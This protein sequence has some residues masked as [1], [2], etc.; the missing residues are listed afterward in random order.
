MGRRLGRAADQR[1]E[2]RSGYNDREHAG[3]VLS[4]ICAPSDRRYRAEGAV[5]VAI[6]QLPL[7]GV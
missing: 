7:A 6:T 3:K 4:H 2:C 5:W 1:Q